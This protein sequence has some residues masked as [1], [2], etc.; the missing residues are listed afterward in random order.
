[1]VRLGEQLAGDPSELTAI[2][3]G[4][5]DLCACR[6]ERLAAFVERREAGERGERRWHVDGKLPAGRLCGRRAEKRYDGLAHLAGEHLAQHRAT[7]ERERVVDLTADD[8]RRLI[9]PRL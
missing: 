6:K 9:F 3:G 1:M 8:A 5:R 2:D 4:P 7:V